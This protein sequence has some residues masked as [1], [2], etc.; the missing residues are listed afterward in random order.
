M[1]NHPAGKIQEKERVTMEKNN[2]K[3]IKLL[4]E[5]IRLTKKENIEIQ[6]IINENYQFM[7]ENIKRIKY[8][9]RKIDKLGG[10]K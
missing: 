4:K 2:D 8:M 7:I 6:E 10:A 3:K 9:E 5:Q 1:E